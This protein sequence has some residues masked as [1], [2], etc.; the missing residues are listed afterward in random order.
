MNEMT[1]EA[2]QTE[3]IQ[4]I[5][6]QPKLVL[7]DDA[8]DVDVKLGV[9]LLNREIHRDPNKFQDALK[10]LG[11]LATRDTITL[12]LRDKQ[13]TTLER[14]PRDLI[15][16]FFKKRWDLE[17]SYDKATVHAQSTDPGHQELIEEHKALR[18]EYLR[19][20]V[21][22]S[23]SRPNKDASS[24]RDTVRRSLFGIFLSRVVAWDQQN[25]EAATQNDRLSSTG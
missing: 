13:Q 15:T 19:K 23:S 22:G 11:D 16:E 6:E 4:I 17:V 24:S 20:G 12:D 14:N 8:I 10:S 21:M 1:P 2:I 5:T 7:D 3:L 25:T 9:R 18:P